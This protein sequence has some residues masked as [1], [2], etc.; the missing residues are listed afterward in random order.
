MILRYFYK[1]FA[2]FRDEKRFFL[3]FAFLSLIAGLLELFGVALTYPFVLKIILNS[4]S[5]ESITV[6]LIGIGIVLLFL[7]KNVFMIFYT[8]LQTRYTNQ[9]E[10]KIKIKFME[11]FLTSQYQ[12]AAQIPFALKNKIFSY[13]IPTVTNNYIFRLLNLCVNLVIFTLITVLLAVKFPVAAFCAIIC[14][15]IL[16]KTQDF[17]YKPLVK[18]ASEKVNALSLKTHQ[19]FNE[20]L[21]DLKSIKVSNNEKYF[22]NRFKSTTNDYHENYSGMSFLNIVPPYVT[23]PFII[24]ML[25]IF[26]AIISFQSLSSPEK[27]V[28]SFALIV[29]AIFRLAP[30]ISRLQVN[31]NGINSAL[32]AVKEFLYIYDKYKIENSRPLSDKV[33]QTFN[34]YIELKGINFG[35][36]ENPVL[37][38]INLTIKKGDFIGI[39]GLSGAGKTTLADVIAGLYKP[40][41][42]EIIIDGMPKVSDLK[43]GYIPQEFTLISGNIREN[44]AFGSDIIDDER[45]IKALKQ[46]QLY[47][48]IEE[49]Y[50]NGIYEAP[51]ADSSG[52]SQG[53]KQRLAIA[54]ALYFEPDI[55]IMDEGTSSLDLIT[56]DKICDTLENLK[57]NKT[58]IVIAHR[59]ST[60]KSADKIIFIKDGEITGNASFEE[61]IKTNSDFEELV[62]LSDISKSN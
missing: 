35:Y 11:Y 44:V 61:L 38:N 54:R 36:N 6:L 9:F 55:L 48:F 30:A 43:I 26:L 16:L 39:A 23:E 8:Y 53:Q 18:K 40:N 56:E 2:Y 42:G 25:F 37:I 14:I 62:R 13:L 50:S 41:G 12:N 20:I 5:E 29:S 22:Y 19:A 47:D 3:N 59:L 57:G 28:A 34:Q 4:K 46:A 31:I 27:L 45:V 60:I 33:F 21:I 32:P 15:L 58:I 10:S 52:I 51:F 24:I 7:I 49:N 1:F 17:V